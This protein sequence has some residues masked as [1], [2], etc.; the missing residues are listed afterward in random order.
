MS[1]LDKIRRYRSALLE[2]PFFFRMVL[3]GLAGVGL[4]FIQAPYGFWF[5]L[6]PCFGLFYF[7]YTATNNK[8][9]AFF[10]GFFFAFGYFVVS[11]NW[12][13]NALLVEGNDY[14]WAWPLA[15]VA[16]PILLSLFTALYVTIA[17]ILFKKN[18]LSSFIGFCTLLALSEWVRGYAFTGF[19]WNLYGYGWASV[20]SI[21]QSLSLFGPY[22]LTFL[23]VIWGASLGFVATKSSGKIIVVSFTLLSLI[24]VYEFGIFRLA[25][26]KLSFV[27]D[28]AI[29]IIQ[30]NIKQEDKWNPYKIRDNFEKLVTLSKIEKRAQKN[31]IIW[32]ETALPPAFLKSAAVHE[33]IESVLGRDSILLT[34]ALKMSSAPLAYYN[35][36]MLWDDQNKM[37]HLYSKTHLVPFGEY[38]P[39]QK[40]IPL[41]PVTNFSGFE[42]GAGAQTINISGYP[43]LSPLICYEII[44]PH[45]AVSKSQPRP[46]YILTITN[47]AW[48][49][50]SPGPYQ[51]F[52]Q[53]RFRAIEQ[54]VP[55]IRAANTGI[56]GLIDSYGRVIKQAGLMRGATITA[57][58]PVKTTMKTYYSMID[59]KAF[60]GF[61][62]LCLFSALLLKRKDFS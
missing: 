57:Q 13:G 3:A 27:D 51:H 34:G 43:S 39:F 2:A 8:K 17:H 42:R 30:P 48:Y 58:L 62:L 5:L 55:V 37:T 9:Q 31:I 7:L 29:H 14:K 47:D 36:L 59:D 19:P 41:E 10:T 40:Y 54:G 28:V 1:F 6:F 20:L 52:Q 61:V 16:L 18:T 15:V 53:A 11:L 49:G 4:S 35:A 56:S 33:R 44:F 26:A 25:G 24:A 23:T 21:M 38:I 50:D 32:P 45:Q 46:D 22:G 12:I 60:L